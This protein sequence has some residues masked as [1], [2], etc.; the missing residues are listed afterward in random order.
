MTI[1]GR[2]PLYY[3]SQLI[4]FTFV[5]LKSPTLKLCLHFHCKYTNGSICINQDVNLKRVHWKFCILK[6]FLELIKFMDFQLHNCSMYILIC[7]S[8]YV[9]LEQRIL[10]CIEDNVKIKKTLSSVYIQWEA[11]ANKEILAM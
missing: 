4:P 5:A 8:N 2:C 10:I 7:T 11:I 3:I 1:T 9:E 6:V